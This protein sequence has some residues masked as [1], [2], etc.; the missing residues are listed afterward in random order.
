VNISY[1]NKGLA[2]TALRSPVSDG[3]RSPCIRSDARY[4][5]G[6]TVLA[7]LL[8]LVFFANLKERNLV[9]SRATETGSA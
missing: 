7:I 4:T 5:V 1:V 8:A 3:R 2:S 9:G 6:T